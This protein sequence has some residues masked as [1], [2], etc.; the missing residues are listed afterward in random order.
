MTFTHVTEGFANGGISGVAAGTAVTT[1][2]TTTLDVSALGGSDRDLANNYAS[3]VLLSSG[4]VNIPVASLSVGDPQGS[5]AS[6]TFAAVLATKA[7]TRQLVVNGTAITDNGGFDALS[8][9]WSTD[10]LTKDRKQLA[11]QTH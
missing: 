11:S 6:G 10:K 7:S 1:V 8:G 5:S 9:S 2:V 4:T 3:T